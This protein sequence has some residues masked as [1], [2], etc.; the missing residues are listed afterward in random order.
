VFE[1]QWHGELYAVPCSLS[2]YPFRRSRIPRL[3]TGR[4][5]A[6]PR[7]YGRTEQCHHTIAHEL[8]YGA[9]IVMYL[10]GE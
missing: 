7:G 5:A 8:R 2:E 10:L 1:P 9:L 6:R 3:H 4:A